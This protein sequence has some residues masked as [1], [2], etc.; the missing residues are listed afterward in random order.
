MIDTAY[1]P[2]KAWMVMPTNGHLQA[3]LAGL[4][5]R[6]LDNAALD[7]RRNAASFLDH[8]KHWQYIFLKISYYFASGSLQTKDPVDALNQKNDDWLPG[9]EISY[10]VQQVAVENVRPLPA[11]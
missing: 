7:H 9:N 1:M 5:G 2:W 4:A 10:P 3:R 6:Q 11:S 8:F